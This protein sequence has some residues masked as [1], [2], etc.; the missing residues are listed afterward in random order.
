[1]KLDWLNI[2]GALIFRRLAAVTD[3]SYVNK[4]ILNGNELLLPDFYMHI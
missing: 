3:K 4:L 1:M 2:V